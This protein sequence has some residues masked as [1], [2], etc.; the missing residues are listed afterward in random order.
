VFDLYPFDKHAHETFTK[1]LF[2][3]KLFASYFSSLYN[4]SLEIDRLNTNKRSCIIVIKREEVYFVENN[5]IVL[6]S[7]HILLYKEI[8]NFIRLNEFSPSF[9]ELKDLTGFSLSRIHK[10]MIDLKDLEYLTYVEGKARTVK[11]L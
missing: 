1:S 5:E 3:C 7:Q 10:F 9:R 4:F 2:L 8:K 11:V 6:T